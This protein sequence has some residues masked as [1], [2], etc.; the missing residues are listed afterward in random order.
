MLH[1]RV[2]GALSAF[3]RAQ[4][5][6]RQVGPDPVQPGR[7]GPPRV[8]ARD[9]LPRLEKRHLDNVP[10]FGIVAE[11]PCNSSV[12]TSRM[13]PDELREGLFVTLLG[14]PGSLAII[15]GFLATTRIAS[16]H[17]GQTLPCHLPLSAPST[18]AANGALGSIR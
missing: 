6:D 7:E 14:A 18:K 17:Q 13:A 8:V 16:R 5:V 1:A 10:G 3:P 12:E 4:H 9:L 11:N 15:H 2:V